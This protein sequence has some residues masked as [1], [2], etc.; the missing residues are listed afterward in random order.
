MHKDLEFEKLIWFL[1]REALDDTFAIQKKLEK[2]T[3]YRNVTTTFI[4]AGV[5]YCTTV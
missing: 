3:A 2:G 1:Q 4:L 5:Y